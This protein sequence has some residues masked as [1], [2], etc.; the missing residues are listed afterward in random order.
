[1]KCPICNSLQTKVIDSREHNANHEIRRRRCCEI[2]NHRFNTFE[3]YEK[4]SFMVEK[5]H[6]NLEPYDREKVERGILRALK[7]RPVDADRI[8]NIINL[9]ER[10]WLSKGKKISAKIIGKDI[11]D[12]LLELDQVAYIRFASVYNDFSDIESFKKELDNIQ[13]NT[14]NA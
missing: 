11:M 2:C 14:P 9:L 3:K 6:S 1:M 4:P 13:N 5:K 7:K 8:N 10:G 12:A